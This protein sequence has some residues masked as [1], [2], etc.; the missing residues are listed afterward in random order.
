MSEFW[1]EHEKKLW[2]RFCRENKTDINYKQIE[3]YV[4]DVTR[5]DEPHYVEGL[6][7]AQRN[8]LEVIDNMNKGDWINRRRTVNFILTLQ[9]HYKRLTGDYLPKN[10]RRL[11]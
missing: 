6:I 7:K 5:L 2:N 1:N 8:R 11:D 10:E 9:E 3:H 4:D